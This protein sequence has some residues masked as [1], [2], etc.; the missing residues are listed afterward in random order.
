M[1]FPYTNNLGPKLDHNDVIVSFIR[2]YG[3]VQTMWNVDESMEGI[4]IAHINVIMNKWHKDA[5]YDEIGL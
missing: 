3:N 4:L 1:G 5:C 2:P